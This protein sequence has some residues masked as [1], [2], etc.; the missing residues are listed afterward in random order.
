MQS[1]TRDFFEQIGRFVSQLVTTPVGISGCG[2]FLITK[3]F[4]V[5]LI[6][7]LVTYEVLQNSFIKETNYAFENSDIFELNFNRS[8]FS[9]SKGRL[10]KLIRGKG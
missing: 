7:A 8:S 2:F 5:T 3:N 6:S 10:S 9:S 1:L 4:M